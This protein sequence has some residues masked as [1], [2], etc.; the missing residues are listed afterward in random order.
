MQTM[1]KQL[2]E[3]VEKL[4]TILEENSASFQHQQDDTQELSPTGCHHPGD[5]II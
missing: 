1:K 4:K 5:V 3:D 2:E